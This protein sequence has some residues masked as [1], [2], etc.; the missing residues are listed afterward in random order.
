MAVIGID[1]GGT[2]VFGA[3]YS[4]ND[5]ILYENKELINKA[6]GDAVFE[7]ISRQIDLLL[8]ESNK[9]GEEVKSIG[10]SVPGIY[11]KDKGTVWAPNIQGWDNYPLLT[12]L[13]QNFKNICFV[14][15]SDR[16]CYIMGETWKGKAQGC[17]NAV[18][19][20][21]GTGIA[22]GI[23]TDGQVLHGSHGIAG[24]IGWLALNKPFEDKY[25]PCG[26]NEYYASGEGMARYAKEVIASMPTYNGVFKTGKEINGTHLI[27][28]YANDPVAKKVIDTVIEYWGMTVANLVSIFNPEKIIFG[29]G[30]FSGKACRFLDMIYSEALKWGQPISMKQVELSCSENG[31]YTGLYGAL[32]LAIHSACPDIRES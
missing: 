12:K 6:T 23:M 14:I 13:E 3:L 32:S 26:C 29:G 22:A 10:F 20:A 2:K 17:K 24:S 25:I 31:S 5:R 11:N 1:L 15:A 30:V 27:E 16:E 18:Y 7:I 28:E 4:L 8:K 9:L 19:I 21:V